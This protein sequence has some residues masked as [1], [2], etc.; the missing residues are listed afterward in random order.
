M[1]FT[2]PE[3][4]SA[5]YTAEA[6]PVMISTRSIHAAGMRL[7][8][9]ADEPADEPTKRRP[10][11]NTSVRLDPRLRRSCMATPAVPMKRLELPMVNVVAS[12]GSCVSTSPMLIAPVAWMSSAVNTLMGVGETT[13]GLEMREPVTTTLSRSVVLS[14][15]VPESPSCA[16][17]TAG[18]DSVSAASR[19]EH[20]RVRLRSCG[21]NFMSSPCD[22]WIARLARGAAWRT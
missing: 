3:T 5:P 17:A 15:P 4:A 16:S 2:T 9:T 20:R 13:F 11:T 19:A 18:A 22:G 7:V 6:P 1:K 8:S 14:S 12:C 10:F 21:I